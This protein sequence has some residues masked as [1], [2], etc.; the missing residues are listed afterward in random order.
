MQMENRDFKYVIQDVS[1]LYIGAKYTY[2]EMLEADEI[3]FKLKA[4]ISHYLLKDD[5]SDLSI[6]DHLYEI[7]PKS[8]GFMTLQQLKIRIRTTTK[9]YKLVEYMDLLEAGKEVPFVEE[10]ILSKLSLMA[11]SEERRVGKE[12]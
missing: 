4:I 8:I 11:R 3:P 7:D 2:R 9:T 12:C 5:I 6:I 1:N 10:I